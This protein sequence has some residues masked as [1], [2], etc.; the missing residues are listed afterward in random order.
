[1]NHQ[2][3]YLIT[4]VQPW[5]L[6]RAAGVEDAAAAIDLAV[7]DMDL[8]APEGLVDL[9]RLIGPKSNGVELAAF[10]PSD[11]AGDTFGLELWAWRDGIRGPGV[12][13]FSTGA[14][15]CV[16]GTAKCAVHPTN[17]DA[18]ENGLWCHAMD[19]TDRWG[20]DNGAVVVIDRGN[21]GIC[22][23]MFDLRG[24][25]YLK[26]HVFAA[27]GSGTECGAVGLVLGG[28]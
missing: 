13:V 7:T 2:G 9:H 25:R 28:F 24:Y 1:M 26:P 19:I 4:T 17:G 21:N 27:D 6:L 11:A 23:V 3:E 12:L 10:T 8:S 20:D 5:A 14:T 16:I 15:G 22:R 18:Q